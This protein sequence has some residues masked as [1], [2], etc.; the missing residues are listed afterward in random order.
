MDT[1]VWL[2]CL[3]RPERLAETARSAIL[4]AEEVVLSVASVWE[5]GIKHGLGKLTLEDGVRP[6]LDAAVR[7]LRAKVL[8]ITTEHVLEA[9]ALP[10]YHR[11]PF[12]RVLIAQARLESLIL[13]SA[14]PWF[15]G[16]DVPML[17]A[18]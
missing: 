9:A 10:L 6:L 11:D 13:V 14:D 16:Y 3:E 18:A 2:W 5:A 8:P 17:W 1:H 4:G 12:D 7:G 15:R